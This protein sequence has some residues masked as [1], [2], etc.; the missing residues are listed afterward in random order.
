MLRC[1]KAPN[2]EPCS[3]RTPQ[4]APIYWQGNGLD[5]REGQIF[6]ADLITLRLPDGPPML[7]YATLRKAVRSEAEANESSAK[8][9]LER[10]ESAKL[11]AQLL[12]A[13]WIDFVDKLQMGLRQVG[14]PHNVA[15]ELLEQLYLNIAARGGVMEL[16]VD[17]PAQSE[18]L[19]SLQALGVTA[20]QH[21]TS[22]DDVDA[23]DR[24]QKAL[25]A[26]RA[27]QKTFA[28]ALAQQARGSFNMFEQKQESPQMLA[29]SQD[30][31][32]E[33]F[34]RQQRYWDHFFSDW[35]RSTEHV[36]AKFTEDYLNIQK[37]RAREQQELEIAIEKGKRLLQEFDR[38][39]FSLYERCKGCRDF[40]A[41]FDQIVQE[42][43]QRGLK[44]KFPGCG[45]YLEDL[46]YARKK[47]ELQNVLEELHAD[48]QA[49]Y[50]RQE[51]VEIR[52]AWLFSS[53]P[54]GYMARNDVVEAEFEGSIERM[55]LKPTEYVPCWAM[56]VPMDHFQPRHNSVQAPGV[57]VR[58]I[59][60]T[61]SRC[62]F[63][64]LWSDAEKY[65][66]SIQHGGTVELRLVRTGKLLK[67]KLLKENKHGATPPCDSHGHLEHNMEARGPIWQ[68]GDRL[69][70]APMTVDIL[71]TEGDNIKFSI[72][73]A[74]AHLGVPLMELGFYVARLQGS[75]TGSVFLQVCRGTTGY[76]SAR[77]SPH[78]SDYFDWRNA[79]VKTFVILSSEGGMHPDPDKL[80]LV[81]RV[82]NKTSWTGGLLG[83]TITEYSGV[84]HLGRRLPIRHELL[85]LRTLKEEHSNYQVKPHEMLT[86]SAEKITT[87]VRRAPVNVASLPIDVAKELNDL[88]ATLKNGIKSLKFPAGITPCDSRRNPD[89]ERREQTL[90]FQRKQG[91]FRVQRKKF[92]QLRDRTLR[93]LK[94]GHSKMLDWHTDVHKLLGPMSTIADAD[95]LEKR[96]MR[97]Y[98]VD[99]KELLR[100]IQEMIRQEYRLDPSVAGH[101]SDAVSKRMQ[102]Q[103]EQQEKLLLDLLQHVVIKLTLG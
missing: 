26:P 67:C 8:E 55:Q 70:L 34:E 22:W 41:Y 42:L 38:A 103:I 4:P 30:G 28:E 102:D 40:E 15:S 18:L 45:H 91:S 21:M 89:E 63:N 19:D 84:V 24:L 48:K 79:S 87:L 69:I 57:L 83:H 10:L 25:D 54:R 82:A 59:K 36:L 35:W 7:H 39:V 64:F 61:H 58:C 32:V 46:N 53:S 90:N 95:E 98:N 29:T 6:L 68:V 51:K 88:K 23:F 50:E 97:L 65:R 85:A 96:V 37:R 11:L 33:L 62:H 73:E 80:R 86:V 13:C 76:A 27:M 3:L 72:N 81:V 12:V 99:M 47:Y 44:L 74:E 20:G 66:R 1:S 60:H 77:V 31:L 52:M 49:L 2:P 43:V 94:D 5:F 17:T 71:E 100:S 14:L 92:E 78:P 101:L 9:L 93:Q 56:A 75:R 16:L